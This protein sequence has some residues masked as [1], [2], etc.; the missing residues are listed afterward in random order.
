MISPPCVVLK[1]VV[2]LHMLGISI[3]CNCMHTLHLPYTLHAQAGWSSVAAGG[4]MGEQDP[5]LQ[6]WLLGNPGLGQGAGRN[7]GD[8][9]SSGS[10]YPQ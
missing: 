8:W 2:L 5:E 10:S 9:A 3:P 1:R 4:G 6:E 7:W